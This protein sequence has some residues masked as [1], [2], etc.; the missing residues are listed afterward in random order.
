MTVGYLGL[1]RRSP[2]IRELRLLGQ[3]RR[4]RVELAISAMASLTD[5]GHEISPNGSFH[6][7]E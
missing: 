3:S 6:L 1:T 4:W 7:R 5:V 2:A